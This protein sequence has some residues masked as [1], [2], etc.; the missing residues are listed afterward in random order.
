MA[1]RHTKYKNAD[2]LQKAIERYVAK[3]AKEK[4]PLTMSGLVVELDIARQ[5]LYDWQE[6]GN[7]F[8]DT[9]KKALEVIERFWEERLGGANATGAIFW[10]KNRGWKDSSEV[11]H[12]GGIRIIT[13]PSIAEKNAI[14]APSTKNSS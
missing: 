3:C 5:T 13:D 8:S 7:Q 14:L 2:E 12:E 9:I 4:R 1:G 6:E 10:L 11:K